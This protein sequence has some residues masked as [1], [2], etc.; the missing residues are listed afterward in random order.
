M[1]LE[2]LIL[3]CEKRIVY[4][5]SAKA[6]AMSMGD[7]AQISLLDEQ[8]TVTNATLLALKSLI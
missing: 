3:M 4:L 1:T 5:N 8:L 7:V 2:F 6:S